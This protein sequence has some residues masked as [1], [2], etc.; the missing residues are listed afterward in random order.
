MSYITLNNHQSVPSGTIPELEYSQ[1]LELNTSM[2][3]N[4]PEK[5]CVLYFGYREKNALR[6]ICCIADDMEHNILVS[7][8]VVKSDSMLNSF[9]ARNLCFEKFEREIHENFG[10]AYS[11]HPWLKPCTLF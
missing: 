11:D 3:E 5:H 4:H 10:I 8:S 1:F 9:S 2:I 7:S 6:L